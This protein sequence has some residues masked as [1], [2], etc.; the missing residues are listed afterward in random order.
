MLRLLILFILTC[1]CFYGLSGQVEKETLESKILHEEVEVLKS[2][3]GITQSTDTINLLLLLDGDE[4]FGLAKDVLELY[5]GDDK[6]YPTIL[7]GLPSTVESRWKYY[8]PT[9]AEPF[10]NSDKETVAFFKSSGEFP[11]YQ[12][13]IEKELIPFVESGS[14]Q[15]ILRTIFGHSM[16]GLGALSFLVG[17]SATFSNYIL[18][19]P[20]ILWDEYYLLEKLDAALEGG[21]MKYG[22]GKIYLTTAEDDLANYQEGVDYFLEYIEELK[23]NEKAEILTKKYE[24]ESHYTVGLKSLFDGILAVMTK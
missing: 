24:G 15:T 21:E 7:I 23:M 10:E 22:F 6:I 17:E 13:F 20:S 8:T 3:I 12:E 11:K 19:S 9:Q 2:E 18:A 1:L 5:V 14:G 16:G 4:Y